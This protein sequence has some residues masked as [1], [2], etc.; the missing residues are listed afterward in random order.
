MSQGFVPLSIS[1]NT[2]LLKEV[3]MFKKW[4]SDKQL[5]VNDAKEANYLFMDGGKLSVPE[6]F[7]E[8][9]MFYKMYIHFLNFEPIYLLEKI[10][11]EFK[12]FLDVDLKR[13]NVK[14]QFAQ[15]FDDFVHFVTQDE[16]VMVCMCSKR[17]GYHF[18]FED[19]V[20][21][22]V[23][24]RERTI[25]LIKSLYI[26]FPNIDWQSVIDL[27]VYNTSLRVVGS[28]KMTPNG[29]EAR[30]YKPYFYI[31]KKKPPKGRESDSHFAK[32]YY[33]K[34]DMYSLKRSLIRH[35]LE[36]NTCVKDSPIQRPIV[37]FPKKDK[38]ID[39]SLLEEEIHMMH[40]KYKSARVTR[41][42]KISNTYCISTDH[43]WCQNKDGC[44]ASNTI[45]FVVSKGRK[46][47]QKCFCRCETLER[48]FCKCKDFTSAPFNMSYKCY[49]YLSLNVH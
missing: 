4:C 6:S 32:T 10:S 49:N 23:S 29:P 8:S 33:D 21:T 30:Y 46:M 15:L 44:H 26:T 28:Q 36:L 22:K 37:N 48:K 25:L 7:P 27:S 18:I 41:V 24:A 20:E 47:R 42:T 43:H 9:E 17:Q 2:K 11:S 1:I 35:S 14:E 16:R 39:Y 13:G 45:Y 5:F 38:C 12:Y 3:V 40:P 31:A 19:A 34:V